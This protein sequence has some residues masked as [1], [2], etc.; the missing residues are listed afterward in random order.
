MQYHYC[1][2]LHNAWNN[3]VWD[4]I[5]IF[6]PVCS[7][8]LAATIVVTEGSVGEQDGEVDDI[9][10]G[11]DKTSVPRGKTPAQA[12]QDFGN[13]VKV[14]RDLPPSIEQQKALLRLSIRGCVFRHNLVR[15]FTPDLAV[16]LGLPKYVPLT[17]RIVVD[18]DACSAAQKESNGPMKA[19]LGAVF[20]E[21][22]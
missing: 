5:T 19:P 12:G 4:L 17:V 16:A 14:T 10:V 7:I 13:V 18:E 9:K 22:E 21:V 20:H 11:S 15:G 2:V 3:L 6:L 8:L 1:V